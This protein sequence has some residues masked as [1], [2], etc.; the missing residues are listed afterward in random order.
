MRHDF[1]PPP[2][3]SEDG[4]KQRGMTPMTPNQAGRAWPQRLALLIGELRLEVILI[5]KLH[6]EWEHPTRH[7]TRHGHSTAALA[8]AP[9]VEWEHAQVEWG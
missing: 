6:V 7:P 9:Q 4:P 8:V 5:L 3:F 1:A 2:G